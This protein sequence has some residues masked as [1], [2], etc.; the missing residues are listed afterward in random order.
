MAESPINPEQEDRIASLEAQVRILQSQANEVA[1]KD[2]EIPIDQ[3][4]GIHRLTGDQYISVFRNGVNAVLQFNE[5]TLA[6][7]VPGTAGGGGGG[8]GLIAQCDEF[9]YT[10]RSRCVNRP[11]L[12][13]LMLDFQRNINTC[14]ERVDSWDMCC[15]TCDAAPSG[16]DPYTDLDRW[17]NCNAES[18]SEQYIY[19]FPEIREGMG[20]SAIVQLDGAGLCYQLDATGV[21]ETP[22]SFTSIANVTSCAAT[23]CEDP[24]PCTCPGDVFSG[25]TVSGLNG[26]SFAAAGTMSGGGLCTNCT[27]DG[28]GNAPWNGT[29]FSSYDSGSCSRAVSPGPMWINIT[30][31]D[32]SV[33]VA[34]DSARIGLD[35]SGC[36]WFFAITLDCDG[37]KQLVWLKE[38]GDTPAGTYTLAPYGSGSF[39]TSSGLEGC[40]TPVASITVS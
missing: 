6:Q 37:T 18:G 20:A 24:A 25:L 5:K 19:L 16:E 17:V 29:G 40:F 13:P 8:G 7:R 33:Q 34:L 2:Q 15:V 32:D 31:G 38:T 9:W 27:N 3:P 39:D 4:R 35:A 11:G 23:G 21:T 22:T 14:V 36:R 12:A 1:A 30:P 28:S 10:F 26:G